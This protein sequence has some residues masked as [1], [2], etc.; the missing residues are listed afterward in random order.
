MVLDLRTWKIPNWLV[1]SGLLMGTGI[2]VINQGITSGFKY[3]LTGC[4][5]PLIS[6]ML[7]FLLKS[8]GGGDIK[9]LSALGSFVGTAIVHIMI[10]SFLAGGAL[11]IFYILKHFYF[12]A[13]GRSILSRTI[14]TEKVTENCIHFSIAI[15]L[16]T[17]Y[18]VFISIRG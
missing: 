8:M 9:L 11:A 4:V 7:L 14:E 2:S 13:A 5:I 16:G 17:V 18:Y 1:L 12:K 3:S 6:L 15:F 10:Y